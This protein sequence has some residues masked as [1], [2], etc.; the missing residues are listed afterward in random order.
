MDQPTKVIAAGKEGLLRYLSRVW[1]FRRLILG[2]ARRDLKVQYAQTLLGVFWAVIQP[3]VGLLVFTLFF[4]QLIKIDTGGIPYPLFAFSG[5]VSWY[6][7]TY[8]IAHAGTALINAQDI[9]TNLYFPK[10]VLPLSKVLTGL[11]EFLISL[12]L[13]TAM[14]LVLGFSPPLVVFALPV[15]LAL[16]MLC[17]LTIA[18]WLSALTVRYRDFKHIIPY[19]VNFGIWLT[20]VFYPG[21]LIPED[22]SWVLYLN[23]MAGVIAGFR[24][25][26][27]GGE[28]PSLLYGLGFIPVM[29]LFVIG[30]WYFRRVEDA[31]VDLI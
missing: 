12:V 27:L 3:L 13:L 22:F 15:F 10:L 8:L 18:I 4:G 11:V 31:V 28:M 26:L 19:L 5:M 23:P 6:F 9:M 17:G 2:L 21:T 7:F 16:N 30:L 1:Q 25:S 24:W 14:M 20:P 29:I